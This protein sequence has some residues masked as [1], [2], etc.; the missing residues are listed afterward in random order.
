MVHQV[1][2]D[3]LQQR[4]SSFACSVPAAAWKGAEQ[5]PDV[6]ALATSGDTQ[7]LQLQM[8]ADSTESESEASVCTAV[9][10]QDLAWG[11]TD[12]VAFVRH[13]GLLVAANE[14][15]THVQYPAGADSWC[16]DQSPNIVL[17]TVLQRQS[18]CQR[19]HGA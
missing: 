18:P 8:L 14:A 9:G 15:I 12:I 4:L 19:L 16:A 13:Q 5:A 3:N 10:R 7:P 1:M 17:S 2:L 6:T 11:G